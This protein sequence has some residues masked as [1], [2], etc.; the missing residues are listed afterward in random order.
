MSIREAQPSDIPRISELASR[1]LVDGP[2]AGVIQDNPQRAKQFAESVL[3]NGK[4]L[5]GEE[6][7]EVIGLLGFITAEH[8]F[9]GQKYAAELMWYVLPEHRKTGIGL[10]LLWEAEKQAKAMGAEDMVFTAPN[11]AVAAIYKRFGYSQLE[12]VCRKRL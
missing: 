5:L 11:E 8:H 4:I 1:S 2:Y 6:D 3:V 7:G 10:K 12:V 9:S